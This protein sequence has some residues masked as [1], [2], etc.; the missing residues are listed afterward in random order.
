MVAAGISATTCRSPS[1]IGV[2]SRRRT[3]TRRRIG[4]NTSG[5]N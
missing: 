5:P 4:A 1:Q 2:D 3:W